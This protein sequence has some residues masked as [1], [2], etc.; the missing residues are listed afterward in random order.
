[1]SKPRSRQWHIDSI[2]RKTKLVGD[3]W[4]WQGYAARNGYG[5]K[6][7]K[8]KTV[9]VHR[10]MYQLAHQVELPT[11]TQVCHSCDTR[12][13]CNPDHLWLGDNQANCVDVVQKGRHYATL[14]THC[15][16]GHAH[17]EHAYITIDGRRNCR[18]CNR[19]RQR[20]RAGWPKEL[21]HLPPVPKGHRPVNANYTSVR[22]PGPRRWD[23]CKRG[24]RMEGDNIYVAPNGNRQCRVCHGEKRRE[25]ERRVTTASNSE[26][27]P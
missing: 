20:L 17:A 25:H 19:I 12:M 7:Y 14:K 1:M 27:A 13:C 8:R 26:P 6:N 3:C 9:R 18:V 23:V 15:P 10:L 21:A 11:E 24:H 5:E 22:A 2:K 16:R 4:I